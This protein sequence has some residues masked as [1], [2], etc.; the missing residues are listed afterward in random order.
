LSTVTMAST[1]PKGPTSTNPRL[2]VYANIFFFQHPV[3]IPPHCSPP[4]TAA[5]ATVLDGGACDYDAAACCQLPS[6]KA[7]CL[8]PITSSHV[9][10]Q[11]VLQM[12]RDRPA[13]LIQ[14]RGGGR[15][16]AQEMRDQVISM[17]MNR[18]DLNAIWIELLRHR[19]KFPCLQTCRRWIRQYQGEGNSRR[20]RPTGNHFSK[21]EVHG[22]DL[23]NLAVYRTVQPKAYI[24]KVRAYVH[25]R[26]PANMPYS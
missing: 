24:D 6:G 3:L 16:Y 7:I 4:L 8:S 2:R 25:N 18:E 17:W 15:G 14:V 21:H 23:V 1:R 20:R 26:N 12:A 5:V 13:H 10:L 19:K 9:V 22:Q 11:F